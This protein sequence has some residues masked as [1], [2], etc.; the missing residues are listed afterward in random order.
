MSR[1]SKQVEK[2]KEDLMGWD[3]GMGGH[4]PQG[5]GLEGPKLSVR[6]SG[7]GLGLQEGHLMARIH[8]RKQTFPTFC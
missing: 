2:R 5:L 7:R 6:D 8:N 3:T 1:D 4:Y